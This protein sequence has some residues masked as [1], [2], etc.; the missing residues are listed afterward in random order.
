[1]SDYWHDPRFGVF[2]DPAVESAQHVVRVAEVADRAGL[3]LIGVQDH[4][5]QRR[6]LDAF[7]LMTTLLARTESIRVFPDVACLPLRP[8]AVLAKTA[9][10]LD[11]LSG[12]RFELGLGAGGFWDAI[13]AIGGPRRAPREAAN[14]LVEATD[15]IR[16]MWSGERS[17]RVDGEIYRLSGVHPGPAPQHGVAI[18]W[19]VLGPR[20]LA[21]LG[22]RAD[23]W[24][25]SASYF[26]PEKLADAHARIDDAAVAAGREPSQI[27]RI[28][29]VFGAI[30]GG[31]S[32]GFLN[33][34]VQQW[35]DELTEL[36]VDGGMDTFVFGTEGDDL[37]TIRTFADDVAPAVR[38]A[39]ASERG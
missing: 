6:F 15:V 35:V 31:T 24:V 4:P 33:G 17:V 1:M 37:D 10:T 34:P 9:A 12:G 13:E 38:A 3:D 2:A 5:Y 39:V 30:T 14:A 32:A 27:R 23:G 29:N 19:G 18:W 21:E 11:I 7:A 8:P 22:R 20:M 16:A 26:P 28:Y 25:P 36:V